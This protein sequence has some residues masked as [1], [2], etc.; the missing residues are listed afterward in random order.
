MQ[1]SIPP[2]LVNGLPGK[3]ATE[4]ARAIKASP[5]IALYNYALTGNSSTR[6]I[7]IDGVKVHL[8][9][10]SQRI[11]FA[12]DSMC[13]R[14]F[15]V[16]YT[17][18]ESAIGNAAFYVNDD[19][20]FVMGTTGFPRE[21]LDAIMQGAQIPAVVASNMA[22]PIV[23]LQRFMEDYSKQNAGSLTGSSL[24]IRESHQAS[25]KDTSGTAKAMIKY[26]V[27]LGVPMNTEDINQ[28]QKIRG[29]ES[30]EFGVPEEYLEGHG[31]HLYYV[32]NPN[33]Q[34]KGLEKLYSGLEDL[35]RSPAFSAYDINQDGDISDSIGIIAKS[36]EK[37]VVFQAV[38]NT[39]SDGGSLVLRH[40]VNGRGIYARGTLEA[41]RFLKAVEIDGR[42]NK[43]YSMI[44][45]L[46]FIEKT[47]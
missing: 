2:V 39:S 38:H 19:M 46:D 22:L 43:V 18:P 23:A 20:P 8:Y 25:K 32:S 29:R 40:N 37:D 42:P 28:F 15:A 33:S 13:A 12:A 27:L 31:W 17:S 30:L 5:D 6:S 34:N 11:F 35:F 4:T 41:L 7:K 26:F 45:V 10:P 1:S 16:D 21:K 14:K 9:N 47:S 3:M 24:K 36:K 44:D